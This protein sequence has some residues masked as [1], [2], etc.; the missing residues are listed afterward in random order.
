MNTTTEPVSLTGY[1]KFIIFLLAIT[2]FSVV[3]DFMV[4]SPLGDM[5]MKSMALTPARFG[6]AVAAYAISAGLSGLLVAGF[7]DRY[8]RKKL[9]VFFYSGFV[10]GTV[11]CALATNYWQLMGARVFTGIFGG[12]IGSVSMAIITDLFSPQQR[13]RVMG[14]VQ[15][16]FAASQV[17]GIPISLKIAEWWGW[18]APFFMVA[19]M[20]TIILMLILGRLQPVVAHLAA[21]KDNNP[22]QHL[23]HNISKP[24]YLNA[25]IVTCLLSIGGFMMMPFGSAFAINNLQLNARDLVWLFM[26]SGIGSLIIMPL[27]GRLADK[28]NKFRL[29]AIASLWTVVMAIVYTNLGP[30]PL[31]V[32]VS[33]NVLMMAG[34]M[35]RMV[36]SMAI[37][38]SVPDMPDRGAF[39]SINSSLQQIAGGIAATAGGYIIT[40][41]TPHSPL[42]HYDTLGYIMSGITIFTI[43]LLYRVYRTSA[44]QTQ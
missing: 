39:M 20:G 25:F 5:L 33:I 17:L 36:P 32:V 44:P 41:E 14:F 1:Q 10:V 19:G 42:Q 23:W 22:L 29:F 15:M 30:T 43:W 2:Q 24:R 11:C 9:L 35:G 26:L 31:W 27:A 13:G 28:V 21:Q 37:V 18:P 38:S 3:L 40:Q 16:G 7:A 6:K 12:V 4:M 34:I 8:D